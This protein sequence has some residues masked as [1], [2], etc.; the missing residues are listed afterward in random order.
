MRDL[1]IA[2]DLDPD[3]YARVEQRFAV[4][5]ADNTRLLKEN[6]DLRKS[7][8]AACLGWL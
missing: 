8:D 4:W 5:A 7:L 3:L 6:A 2:L 1:K